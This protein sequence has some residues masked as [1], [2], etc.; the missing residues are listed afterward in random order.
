MVKVLLFA[1]MFN[2]GTQSQMNGWIYNSRLGLLLT[3]VNQLRIMQK[4]ILQNSELRADNSKGMTYVP[5]TACIC[6]FR[7]NCVNVNDWKTM[8][9]RKQWKIYQTW[10]I[11]TFAWQHISEIL[12]DARNMRCTFILAL[13][14]CIVSNICGAAHKGSSAYY[15]W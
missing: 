15:I 12:I 14:I 1:S 7:T 6:L 2:P 4:A 8:Q 5:L 11:T 3:L 9:S 10:Q 13:V